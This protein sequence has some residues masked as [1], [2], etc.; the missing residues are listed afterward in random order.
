MIIKKKQK[1]KTPDKEAKFST[2]KKPSPAP[3]EKTPESSNFPYP[4]IKERQERRRGD[5]RRGYRRIDDRNLLSRAQEEANAIKESASREG[6]E[7]GVDI[8]KEE[9]RKLNSAINEFISAKE[10][11]MQNAV[12]DI[13]LL[14]VKAAEKMVKKELEI[15]EN[16]ILGVVSEVIQSVSKDE[17]E[18]K[19]KTNPNDAELV[20]EK[21]P[22]V[23]PYNENTKIMV[24]PDEDV[25][26]GS[27]IVE[28]RN[29]IVD[30]RFSTQLQ[31][32]QK[33]LEAGL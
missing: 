30:A 22:E 31:I 23:Y 11:V 32:L 15:D 21:L 27:C 17:T 33:A 10:R 16:V 7:Y 5:R 2:E 26:W 1:T 24:I 12:P 4:R 3:V 28:T 8:S 13:A 6:F 14:A 25:D 19:I 9:I 20:R 18:I 29:G